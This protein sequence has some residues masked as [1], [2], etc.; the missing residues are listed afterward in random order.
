MMRD[1]ASFATRTLAPPV[2]RPCV[3]PRWLIARWLL[4]LVFPVGLLLTA[5]VYP[6]EPG[7]FWPT[8]LATVGCA[9]LLSRLDRP[10]DQ[11][12]PI[13]VILMT[14]MLGYYIKF[15]WVAQV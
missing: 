12:L 15:Y 9:L 13:W 4:L 2:R 6:N 10:A 3:K 1:E 11:T 5:A 14:F 7:Y 8:V